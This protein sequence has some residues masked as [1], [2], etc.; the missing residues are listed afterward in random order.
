MSFQVTQNAQDKIDSQ[1][2]K[3]SLVL[4]I[5]GYDY[6]FSLSR[7]DRVIRVGDV[8]LTVD[9]SWVIGG[10]RSDESLLPYISLEGTTQSISQQMQQDKGGA[11]SV[12][13][14]QVSII[15]YREKVTEL[16]SP[17]FVLDD[18]LG[19]SAWVYLGFQDTLFPE[20]HVII[21]SGIIDEISAT[22]NITLNIAHPEQLKRQEI[23]ISTETAL[24]GGINLI[25]T[26]ITLDSVENFLSPYSTEFLTY[27][28]ID[29]EIIR[30]TGINTGLNQLTGCTRAQFG[31]VA[32]SHSDDA[33]VSSFYRLIGSANDL[34]LKVLMSGPDEYWVEDIPVG[35]FVRSAAGVDTADTIFIPGVDIKQK[36]GVNVG[37][38]LTTTL[39]TN[40]ANNVSLET[41]SSIEITDDGSIITA[42]GAGFVLEVVSSAL[43]K[44][45]S[46]YNVLPDGLGLGGSEVDVEE[47][48]RINTIFASYMPDFDFYLTST[49]NGKEFVDKE[50][51]Y[52]ANMFSLPRK[53]RV[54]LGVVSPPLA[55]A[56]LPVIDASNIIQPEKISIKRTI[57]R[58]FYNTVIYKYDFDAVETDKPL[59]GYIRID[60]DSKN[61]IKKVG[62]KSLVINS[63]GLRNT[64][65]TTTILDINTQRVLDRYKFAAEMF[66][67][68]V[69]Y[70]I[71]YLIEVGD[72]VY[73]GD[74][75][76]R[77]LD[78]KNGR[79]G[80]EPRL[81]EIVDKKMNIA[82]GRIDLTLVDTNYSTEGRYGIF[83][84]ASIVGVGST[85]TELVI[86]SSYGTAAYELEKDKWTGYIGENLLIHDANWTT[87]YNTVLR[88]FDPSDPTIM[89]IDSIGVS[90]SAGFIVEIEQYSSS[91]NPEDSIKYKSIHCYFNPTISVASGTS[92]T[93][94]SVGAG[95]VSKLFVGATIMVHDDDFSDYSPEVKVT[96]IVGTTVTVSASL[97][98]TPSSSHYI[99][100]VG[101]SSDEGP[102]YRWL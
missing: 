65:D 2:K 95:D 87:T 49:V 67:I 44:F 43:I 35:N 5:D 48:N 7:L 25:V 6:K 33:S 92:N 27:V 77:I 101:F 14:I 30:Y 1:N 68:S 57:G 94:F 18:L 88:G 17:G 86:T 3:P 23:F 47:F 15:D 10:T 96:D 98:F 32:A 55:V 31:T 78:S 13:S 37:D 22:G 61:R 29:D 58:Y 75:N 53:G 38:Y 64:A 83:S 99:E 91:S 74:E 102:A 81:C 19:R 20:D 46:Q 34:A 11:S 71:G 80:F 63:K 4:E 84:P 90:L 39:A 45:K 82:T 54:S 76:L 21:F 70:G 9:G 85:P 66:N 51:L 100:Y 41:I 69:F 8:G 93:V 40:S 42:S 97:G 28:K 79:R 24:N 73:F 52:P 16:V 50:I 59:A 62:T 60:E 56:T 36:Y 12:S 26:T 89:L 72:I